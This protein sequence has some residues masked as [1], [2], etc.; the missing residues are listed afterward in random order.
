MTMEA[1]LAESRAAAGERLREFYAQGGCL[2][3]PNEHRSRHETWR[4]YKH[5]HELRFRAWD[6]SESAEILSLLRVVGIRAGRTYLNSGRPVIPVY[7][8]ERVRNAIR[9]LRLKRPPPEARK[10]RV[11]EPR[12]TIRAAARWPGTRALTTLRQ[13]DVVGFLENWGLL[14]VEDMGTTG[15]LLALLAKRGLVEPAPTDGR[16][17]TTW[18][19]TQKGRAKAR[20]ARRCYLDWMR[21]RPRE[22]RARSGE[23]GRH[24]R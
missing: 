4:T 9:A 8:A 2:R 12:E 18:R 17:P 3:V 19:L 23:F 6:E 20:Q 13:L 11:A 16:Q 10:R 5:G 7:G 1:S 15:C 21:A 24:G 22:P 14:T